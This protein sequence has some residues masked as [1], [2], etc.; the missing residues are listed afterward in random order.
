MNKFYKLGYNLCKW[1]HWFLCKPPLVLNRQD[2]LEFN[3]SK[4]DLCWYSVGLAGLL[5]EVLLCLYSFTYFVY[6]A[7]TYKPGIVACH[8]ATAI[9]YG[10]FVVVVFVIWWNREVV[11][12]LN[13]LIRL[14]TQFK[15]SKL[16]YYRHSL[17]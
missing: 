13:S 15:D 11:Y 12:G 1:M 4:R 7:S 2:E 14:R 9:M 8:L 16:R 5:I 10:D 3:Y 6:P 17:Y